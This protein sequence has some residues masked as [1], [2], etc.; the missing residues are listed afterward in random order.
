MSKGKSETQSSCK[1][2][3]DFYKV[4]KQQQGGA[5]ISS[6]VMAFVQLIE[7]EVTK[8]LGEETNLQTL[9]TDVEKAELVNTEFQKNRRFDEEFLDLCEKNV[10]KMKEW[11]EMIENVPEDQ[12]GKFLAGMEWEDPR[13]NIED[14][15]DEQKQSSTGRVIQ[16][17]LETRT[18]N[19][20]GIEKCE[21][22]WNI[23]DAVPEVL[24]DIVEQFLRQELPK[25]IDEEVALVEEENNVYKYKY[26]GFIR[27]PNSWHEY[28]ED[29]ASWKKESLMNLRKLMKGKQ[30]MALNKAFCE[31]K[32]I[33]F[34]TQA[35]F[36]NVPVQEEW[37]AELP[38]IFQEVTA[39]KTGIKKLRA[40]CEV[41]IDGAI[42]YP[43]IETELTSIFNEIIEGKTG[44]QKHQAIAEAWEILPQGDRGD[45]IELWKQEI[46]KILEEVVAEIKNTEERNR[47]LKRMIAGTPY[48]LKDDRGYG[49][50]LKDEEE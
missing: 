34:Y 49:V 41:E 6:K 9:L 39:G 37:M 17:V 16:K 40:M 47:V 13:D 2:T 46:P 11:A 25:I 12:R 48:S 44:E 15:K 4:L 28:G 18:K 36:M 22:L 5:E 8:I 30:G 45:I 3:E 43:Y 32:N 23:W 19:Q 29:A 27:E 24:K 42:I 35:R 14:K 31:M 26:K 20:K 50:A 1:Y 21:T 7:E 38:N 33:I 10:V